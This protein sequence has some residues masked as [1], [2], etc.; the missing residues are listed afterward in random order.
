MGMIFVRKREHPGISMCF[1]FFICANILLHSTGRGEGGDMVAG[2]INILEHGKMKMHIRNPLIL[3]VAARHEAVPP[4][5]M[6][7]TAM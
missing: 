6:V 2:P 5:V 7:E 3:E 4:E 1:G